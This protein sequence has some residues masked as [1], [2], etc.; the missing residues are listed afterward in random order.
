M[1]R[2]KISQVDP[3]PTFTVNQLYAYELSTEA[4]GITSLAVSY[5]D[6]NQYMEMLMFKDELETISVIEIRDLRS[7]EYTHSIDI[8]DTY[9]I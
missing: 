4:Y 3:R 9:S 8:A 1:E 6:H 2:F 7:Q 5:D